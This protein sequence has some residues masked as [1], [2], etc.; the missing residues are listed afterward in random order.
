MHTGLVTH[1]KTRDSMLKS[2]VLASL[3][4]WKCLETCLAPSPHCRNQSQLP[5]LNRP[6][7]QSLMGLPPSFTAMISLA[8]YGLLSLRPPYYWV[9]T[10]ERPRLLS[11]GLQGLMA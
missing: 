4:R 10:L 8:P 7:V 5:S 2:R 3:G 6:V 11:P 9:G 1:W